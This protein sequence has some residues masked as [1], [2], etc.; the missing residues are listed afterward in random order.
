MGTGDG[1]EVAGDDGKQPE[2][3]S[4]RG[5]NNNPHNN[6]QIG[7]H[8]LLDTDTPFLMARATTRTKEQCDC[9]T[10]QKQ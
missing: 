6:M 3:I 7:L 8:H 5:K 10:A 4:T 9:F 2:R 1:D